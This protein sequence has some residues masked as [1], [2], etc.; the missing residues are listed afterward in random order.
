M[1]RAIFLASCFPRVAPFLPHFLAEVAA[2]SPGM[3]LPT[4]Q[5]N[6][7]TRATTT[8]IR[9][10]IG[11][12]FRVDDPRLG[13]STPPLHSTQQ[14]PRL[15]YIPTASRLGPSLHGFHERATRRRLAGMG[16]DVRELDVMRTDRR[17][18]CQEITAADIIFVDG[19]NTFFLLQELR[20]T[21][22]DVALR[23]AVADGTPYIGISAGA[24]VT[25]PDIEHI[26]R[27]DD[28]RRAGSLRDH[29]GLGLVDFRIVP[30]LTR[31]PLRDTAHQILRTYAGDDI[32]GITDR[33]AIVVMGDERRIISA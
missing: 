24:V 14:K 32:V 8:K 20:R 18:A 7:P 25:G 28:P 30:H 10:K 16:F 5:L 3:A 27:M 13:T 23:H 15:C 2:T 19:G 21:G 4:A 29:R 26:S 12:I 31:N 11:G 17:L 6:L 1:T 22:A 9:G 33:Q